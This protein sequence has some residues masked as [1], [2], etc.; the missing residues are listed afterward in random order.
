M[1][2]NKIPVLYRTRKTKQK[3]LGTERRVAGEL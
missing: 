3:P 1:Y 2:F